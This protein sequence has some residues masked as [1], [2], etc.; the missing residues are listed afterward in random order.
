M[1][2]KTKK[3][4]YPVVKITTDS[5]TYDVAKDDKITLYFEPHDCRETYGGTSYDPTKFKIIGNI[6]RDTIPVQIKGNA[7]SD[8]EIRRNGKV[9]KFHIFTEEIKKLSF[10]DVSANSVTLNWEHTSSGEETGYKIYRDGELI[11]TADINDR[12]YTDTNLVKN[13]TYKYTVKVT[14]D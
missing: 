2:F 4:Q 12:S 11:H 7:G 10:S 9:Y 13:H 5:K 6:D 3:L 8:F 14:N 1:E